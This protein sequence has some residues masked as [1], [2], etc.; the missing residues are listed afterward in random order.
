MLASNVSSE[1]GVIEYL[2]KVP[3]A[4]QLLNKCRSDR[5]DTSQKIPSRIPKID[6]HRELMT[7]PHQQHLELE[8]C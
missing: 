2:D 5:L 4:G 8:S 6:K 3:L 7:M 1:L